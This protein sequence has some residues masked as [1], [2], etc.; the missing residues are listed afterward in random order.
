VLICFASEARGYALA[1]FFALA[2][3]L[4]LD[5]FLANRSIVANILFVM[6]TILG[7]LSHLTFVEVYFALFT[8]S[9]AVCWQQSKT[10]AE[11]LRQLVML[12][13]VPIVAMAVLYVIDIRAM[14][15][16]GGDTR[17]IEDVVISTLALTAG[18]LTTNIFLQ[19]FLGGLVFVAAIVAIVLLAREGSMLW[20][21]FASG[22][23]F[24]PMLL[25]TLHPPELIYERY[26]YVNL[27]LLLV[28][29]SYLFSRLWVLRPVGPIAV[30]TALALFVAANGWQTFDF[31]RVGRGHFR[32]ALELILESDPDQKEIHIA[33]DGHR[34]RPVLYTQFYGRYVAGHTFVFD[35]LRPNLKKFPE[36]MIIATGEQPYG[37]SR[38]LRFEGGN[39]YYRIQQVFPYAGISGFTIAVYRWQNEADAQPG[40]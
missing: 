4:A 9:C 38:D 20:L 27:V 23:F 18:A 5:R 12:H 35:D 26:F 6:A 10:R 30:V 7:T 17:T 33:N 2:A 15:I 34:S 22:I 36:W 31:L 25:L 3:L 1:G 8:W 40:P 21:F 39:G 28:L 11:A 37:D 32:E 29:F 16:G 24:A 19:L 13:A 14:K